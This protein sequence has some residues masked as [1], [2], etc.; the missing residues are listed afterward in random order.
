MYERFTD[1][2]RK[3]M[4]L[5]NLEAQQLNYERIDTEHI[6]LGLLKE[7]SGVAAHVLRGFDLDPAALYPSIAAHV[8]PRPAPV[9]SSPPER[10]SQPSVWR[11]AVI[12]VLGRHR[13]K[14]LPQT[15]A[16]KRVIEYAM[17]EAQSLRH[18]YIGTEHILLGLSQG[19][20][21][22]AAQLLA[23]RGLDLEKIRNAVLALLQEP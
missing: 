10:P 12:A 13:S 22:L 20:D 18:N 5:A 2:A 8:E 11:H 15:S 6:L 16:T 1:R 23:E 4:Q 3:V 17:T 9:V 21:T 14:R 7:G 19:G